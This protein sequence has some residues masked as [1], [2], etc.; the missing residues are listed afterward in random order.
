MNLEDLQQPFAMSDIEWRIG[1]GGVKNNGEPW[2]TLL[3]YITNRAIM[4]RLDQV[5]G[6]ENWQNEYKEA[7]CG[8]LLCGLSIYMAENGSCG[9]WVTKWDG[10]ENTQFESVKGGLS[11]SMKRA[12]VHWGIGRY[13]YK[14]TDNWATIVDKNTLGALRG[15]VK[16][17]NKQDHYFYYLPPTLP[18]WALAGL[19]KDAIKIKKAL[20]ENDLITAS[21]TWQK[22]T[23]DEKAAL[24]VAPTKGGIFTTKQR[25][26]MKSK[27]FRE[28]G[29]GANNG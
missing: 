24:W 18:E 19:E 22:L 13:L 23:D 2:A 4:D 27:E 11:G 1:R 14:L 6:P 7:P 16:D 28:A 21:K 20:D 9:D 25:E 3:A 5:V 29:I 17:K 10:A 12:A 8:G 15:Q 26:I